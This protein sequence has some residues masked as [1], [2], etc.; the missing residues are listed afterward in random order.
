MWNVSIPAIRSLQAM[1]MPDMPAPM[2]AT[3]GVRMAAIISH[4]HCGPTPES[5]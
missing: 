2:I 1:P 3:L 4:P 5:G